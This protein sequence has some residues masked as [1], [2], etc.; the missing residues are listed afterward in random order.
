MSA[1]FGVVEF[2]FA[3]N[4]VGKRNQLIANR[5]N[6]VTNSGFKVC[7]LIAHE[8]RLDEFLNRHRERVG[9]T[10]EDKFTSMPHINPIEEKPLATCAEG[11]FGGRFH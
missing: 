1:M 3:M 5:I 6:E 2:G 10:A 8:Q 11:E 4:L 9:L 7:L